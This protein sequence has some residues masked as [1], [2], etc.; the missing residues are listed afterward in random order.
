M[1]FYVYAY[2][3]S[4]DFFYIGKGNRK[5]AFAHLRAAKRKRKGSTES[6]VIRHCRSLLNKGEEPEIRF[7]IKDIDELTALAIE[8]FWIA[9]IGRKDLG[10]GPLLNK[11]NGGDGVS[12]LKQSKEHIEKR[13]SQLRNKKYTE[14]R[15]QL[16]RGPRGPSLNGKNAQRERANR[17]KEKQRVSNFFKN[18][19]R[20]I[21]ERGHISATMKSRGI[22]PK[23]LFGNKNPESISG[24]AILNNKITKFTCLKVF[25]ESIGINYS[26]A[27]NTFREKRSVTRGKFV[28]FQILSLTRN[29]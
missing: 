16:M 26:T 14:E 6:D 13:V 27:R 1:T 21:V 23:P 10:K 28:G 18:R 5:R 29:F 7:I 22:K 24:T 20:P 12:G 9:T 4:N 19:P 3:D 11:T 25:C 17:P 2:L 15:K 8:T